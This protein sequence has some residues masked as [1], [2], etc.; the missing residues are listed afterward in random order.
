MKNDTFGIFNGSGT[1]SRIS[2]SVELTR[3]S[4][5]QVKGIFWIW[6]G[7]LA[8]GK[9]HIL[10][11]AAGTGKTNIAMWMAAIISV[12]SKGG[13]SWPGNIY[14]PAGHVIIWTGED[15]IEDTILPRLMALGANLD[16]IHVLRGAEEHGRKRPFDFSL[17]IGELSAEIARIG[18]VTL[19][20]IDSIVQ[21]VAGDSN[22]NSDVRQSLAPL[23]DIAERHNFAVLGIT[24]LAKGSSKKDPLDRVAGSMAFGAVARVVMVTAKIKSNPPTEGFPGSCVLVRAKSNIGKDDGGFEYQIETAEFQDGLH[25]IS[26]SRACFNDT[27]LQGAAKEILKFAET[28]NVEGKATKVDLAAEFL[29]SVLANG[30]LAFPEIELRAKDAGIAMS[31]IVR[32]KSVLGIQS[33]KQSGIGSVSPS[34]WTFS[35]SFSNNMAPNGFGGIASVYDSG[36][37]NLFQTPVASVASVAPVAPVAP[38][39]VNIADLMQSALLSKIDAM[40]AKNSDSGGYVDAELDEREAEA[41]NYKIC[42]ETAYAAAQPAAF[43]AYVTTGQ[44]DI[45]TESATKA[46]YGATD[47][48]YAA[49]DAIADAVRAAITDCSE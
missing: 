47:N 41:K 34:I 13:R 44:E 35:P 42:Y 48:S 4:L 7:W 11:G 40:T 21:V 30:P 8:A 46:A 27:P 22:K 38:V 15:S 37:H 5:I 2:K 16:N 43:S 3:A 12:G 9:L 1:K 19:V 10:A 39:D 20:I 32:A 29:S 17:D 49:D 23:V 33:Q 45:A 24:H 36:R 31:A 26:T 25:T 18:G 14:A 6:F 28:D